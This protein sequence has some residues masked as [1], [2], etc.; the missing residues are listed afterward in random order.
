MKA[1]YDSL[2]VEATEFA[3]YIAGKYNAFVA[4]YTT[5]LGHLVRTT[6]EMDPGQIA[7]VIELRTTP[8]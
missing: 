2:M 3:R 1:R 7:Y 4:E 8:Q 6:F 5:C